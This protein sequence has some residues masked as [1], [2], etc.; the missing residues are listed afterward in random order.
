MLLRRRRG[1][2]VAKDYN[3]RG[4]LGFS[5]ILTLLSQGKTVN[6]PDL[7]KVHGFHLCAKQRLKQ[8]IRLSS[9]TTSSTLTVSRVQKGNRREHLLQREDPTMEPVAL[10]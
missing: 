10:M 6:M 2:G 7:W 1:K 4:G 3:L 9:R 8:A 5:C